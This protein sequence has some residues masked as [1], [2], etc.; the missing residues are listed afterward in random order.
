[1]A[2]LLDPLFQGQGNSLLGNMQQPGG[3][4]GFAGLNNALANYGPTL[5]ALGGGIAAHGVAGFGDAANTAMQ[6]NAL[7]Y[8]QSKDLRDFLFRMQESK[9]NQGNIEHEFQLKE[10]PS[11][12]VTGQNILSQ[13][14]YG[15]INTN[16]Q[17]IS[18]PTSTGGTPSNAAPGMSE[19]NI[20]ESLPKPQ[21][22]IVDSMVAGRMA[23]PSSF[24]L[25]TPYWNTLLAAA[26]ERA[27]ANGGTFDAAL[28]GQK[29]NANKDLAPQGKS[30][31]TINALDTVQGHIEKLSDAV[32][33]LDNSDF[34]AYN[35][36]R[37]GIA[38]YTPLDPARAQKLQAAKDAIKP[39]L[40]EMSRA[41]KGGHMSD[42]EIRSWG[43]LISGAQ[44]KT[45][46]RQAIADF[47][48][49]LN[50]KRGALATQYKNL[51]VPFKGQNDEQN[52]RVTQ[53]VHDRNAGV[54]SGTPTS[55][56]PTSPQATPPLPGGAGAAAAPSVGAGSL[57]EGQTATNPKT[58]E[59]LK[60]QGGKWVPVGAQLQL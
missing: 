53:I 59:K 47:T 40:D 34:R 8:S 27:I 17:T 51:D 18:S 54:A 1:M 43:E 9:R 6:Q 38:D 33:K 21:R 55:V 14:Q 26:N 29:F 7:N 44:G 15:F 36:V 35:A 2:S 5:M 10:R 52:A 42:T 23:P 28:W 25:K 12:G 46:Q 58:G 48:D 45:Q 31:Q 37:N 56:K 41:Y 24:A 57:Q 50:T 3:Q 20:Y 60:F 22:D 49:F 11:F 4:P 30:G 13:P 39:V 32:E 19:G 16:N